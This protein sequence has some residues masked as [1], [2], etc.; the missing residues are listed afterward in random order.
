MITL[1][2]TAGELL[3]RLGI[4]RL[5]LDRCTAGEQRAQ[6]KAAVE[7]AQAVRRAAR[8]EAP[9]L[10][11][12]EDEL[13]AINEALWNAEDEIR[14]RERDGDHGEAFVAV[15]R[16]IC[17]LNDRRA[18][19]KRAVDRLCGFPEVDTKSYATERSG[20]SSFPVACAQTPDPRRP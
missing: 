5:K 1:E 4:L 9:G 15:A 16:A 18:A 14:A 17:R 6:L 2:V 12:L 7:R 10:E 8:V 11:A 20:P 3:D 19:V 13:A